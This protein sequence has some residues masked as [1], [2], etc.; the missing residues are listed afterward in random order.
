MCLSPGYTDEK[1]KQADPKWELKNQYYLYIS[2]TISKFLLFR[3]FQVS[4]SR[5]SHVETSGREGL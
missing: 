4:L 5:R 3:S 1:M 2:L